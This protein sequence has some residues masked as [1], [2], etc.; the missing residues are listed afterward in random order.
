MST[1]A[2]IIPIVWPWTKYTP[3]FTGFGT[4]TV[5]EFFWSRI[6]ETLFVRG[7][8]TLGTTTATEARIS[9]PQVGN[10]ILIAAGTNKIHSTLQGAGWLGKSGHVLVEPKVGYMTLSL[11]TNN[12]SMVV[13][14]NGNAWSA[15]DDFSVFMSVPVAGWAI[16]RRI[17]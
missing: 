9:Y 6:G 1:R 13:K 12:A 3:I 4:V 17:R 14:Q 2:P 5:Q 7:R 11:N 10:D 16:A 8:F 15:G